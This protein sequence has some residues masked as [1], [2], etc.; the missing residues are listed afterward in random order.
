ME[1]GGGMDGSGD[2]GANSIEVG[3]K[4]GGGC[5]CWACRE[6]I[7]PVVENRYVPRLAQYRL[8]DECTRL[9]L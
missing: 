2:S 4:R 6:R 9:C 3:S 7:R 1:G 8:T 5:H